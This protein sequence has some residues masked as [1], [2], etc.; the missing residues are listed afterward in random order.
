MAVIPAKR[1]P[2]YVTDVG[3]GRQLACDP[4]YDTLG[5]RNSPPNKGDQT[6]LSPS[7]SLSFALYSDNPTFQCWT[8]P[9]TFQY[10]LED[11]EKEPRDMARRTA[12]GQ[13]RASHYGLRPLRPATIN[14]REVY[15]YTRIYASWKW[16]DSSLSLSLSLSLCFVRVR[17]FFTGWRIT[18]LKDRPRIDHPNCRNGGGHACV[19][20]CGFFSFLLARNGG[21][22]QGEKRRDRRHFRRH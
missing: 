11:R 16:G 4:R 9:E 12:R 5:G 14:D 21:E 7:L 3:G 20:T 18:Q 1:W 22:F 10:G 17:K 2:P 15:I 13:I 19:L 8:V 6:G